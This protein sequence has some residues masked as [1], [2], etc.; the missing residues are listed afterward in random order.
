MAFVFPSKYEGFGIPVLEAMRCG[1]PVLLPSVS[2]L[3]EVA[4]N[5]GVYFSLDEPL[6]LI[7]LLEKLISDPKYR[8]QVVDNGFKQERKFSWNK[9]AEACLKIYT[10]AIK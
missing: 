4:G 8:V 9:T 2:S 1:C 6:G 10:D 7:L 5:G 3:P